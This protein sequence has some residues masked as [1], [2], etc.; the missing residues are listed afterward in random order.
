MDRATIH[1][2]DCSCHSQR[3]A[4]PVVLASQASKTTLMYLYSHLCPPGTKANWPLGQFKLGDLTLTIDLLF[5]GRADIPRIARMSEAPWGLRLPFSIIPLLRPIGAGQQFEVKDR[6]SKNVRRMQIH[7]VWSLNKN[8]RTETPRRGEE[9]SRRADDHDGISPE[10]LSLPGRCNPKP[11]RCLK[12]P[13][14][15]NS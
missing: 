3:L 14:V 11:H 9:N 1:A 4:W 13:R 12:P 10:A 8:K 6:S 15:H 5:W 2:V 7:R